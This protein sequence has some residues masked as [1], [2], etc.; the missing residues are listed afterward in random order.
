MTAQLSGSVESFDVSSFKGHLASLVGASE[1][2]IHLSVAPAS[3]RVTARIVAP[4]SQADESAMIQNLDNLT[5]TSFAAEFGVPV[6]SLEPAAIVTLDLP[7]P[8]PPPSMPPPSEPPA[9]PPPLSLPP[10]APPVLFSAGVITWMTTMPIVAALATGVAFAFRLWRRLKRRSAKRHAAAIKLQCAQRQHMA[11][12]AAGKLKARRRLVIHFI[13]QLRMLQR[14]RAIV[15]AYARGYLVRS[16]RRLLVRHLAAQVLQVNYRIWHARQCRFFRKMK[17]L[18][19]AYTRLWRRWQRWRALVDAINHIEAENGRATQRA[20]SLTH[21]LSSVTGWLWSVETPV[22]AKHRLLC[23]LQLRLKAPASYLSDIKAPAL[24]PSDAFRGPSLK[25]MKTGGVC[26]FLAGPPV[27]PKAHSSSTNLT[28]GF[29]TPRVSLPS[30]KDFFTLPRHWRPSS[31]PST[32]LPFPSPAVPS[33][34]VSPSP[35]LTRGAQGLQRS[36]SFQPIASMREIPAQPVAS[37]GR[38]QQ[39]KDPGISTGRSQRELHAYM[40]SQAFFRQVVD[41]P[42]LANIPR[43]SPSPPAEMVDVAGRALSARGGFVGRRRE[44]ARSLSFHTATLVP[45]KP[46]RLPFRLQNLAANDMKDGNE[47]PSP[48]FASDRQAEDPRGEHLRASP[49]LQA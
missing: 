46:S 17:T 23:R 32:P 5:P 2:D 21:A 12:R 48:S 8:S 7:V 10:L 45:M 1:S 13:S 6:E 27:D 11:T 4:E 20:S 24:Y 16:K 14:R 47:H 34:R 43:L 29:T 25:D 44:L 22:A 19:K 38:S 3:I 18:A 42:R 40:F 41:D 39:L 15:Q 30:T 36:L 49:S 28:A 9:S 35:A 26:Q 33:L 37:A 31:S